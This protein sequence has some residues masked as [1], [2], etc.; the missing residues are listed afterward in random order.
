MK[1]ILLISALML[2]GLMA[3]AQEKLYLVFEFMKVDNEQ[4]S[5]YIETE[6][7]WQKLHEARVKN[8]DI[9]GWD[10]W[11][12]RPGGEDQ[13]FQY[14]TVTLYNDPVKMME[15]GGFQEAFDA[16]FSNITMEEE[17]IMSATAKTRDLAVRIYAHEI[18]ATKGEPGVDMPLGTIAQMDMMKVDMMN[19]GTYEKAEK[20]VFMPLHQKAVD[21][22]EKSSWGLIR[23]M[24]PVGSDTYAS[25]MTV[26]MFDGFK[27]ALNQNIK[28]DEG[29][30]P[31]QTKM[32]QEGMA[33]RDMKYVYMAKLIK[34]VR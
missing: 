30:T 25:H 18:L 16:A 26:S 13:G 7:L 1:K 11:A 19:Y 33:A 5:A 22:G 31:A 21:A 8:G 10:L 24:N 14:L 3:N 2:F 9:I 28:W 6:G 20:E 29:A 27:Q 4:E 34:I 17:K 12:L 15:G 23:F 32:M